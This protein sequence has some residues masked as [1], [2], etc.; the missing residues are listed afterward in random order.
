MDTAALRDDPRGRLRWQAPA[1]VLLTTLGLMAFL[2]VLQPPGPAPEPGTIEIAVAE[3]PPPAPAPAA[4][5]AMP[6]PVATPP[7][8]AE[9][10]PSVGRPEPPAA[11]PEPAARETAPAPE[12]PPAPEP[13]PARD[14]APA[15]PPFAPPPGER[16]SSQAAPD[17]APPPISSVAPP[18]ASAS[19]PQGV[20]RGGG[21]VG[22]RVIYQPMPELP[23][24]LRRRAIE[25]V[26][27]ARFSVTASGTAQVELTEP[28]ADPE[29]NR[30]LLDSLR[31]WRFF[32]AMRNGRP[33]A[34]TIDIRI[35]ISVR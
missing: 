25:V 1:A 11:Q 30:A 13:A 16:S 9:P 32:P 31:R 18:S 20:E 10:A 23:E 27:V 5:R 15:P 21:S 34:S 4:S 12:T 19:A 17:S 7:R 26:A 28:T 14:T 6:R 2:R 29:L 22:A 24:A 33:A 8:R 3:P 35:P